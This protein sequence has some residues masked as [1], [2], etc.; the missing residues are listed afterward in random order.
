LHDFCSKTR[1]L[2]GQIDIQT[3]K[4]IF[5]DPVE[6]SSGRYCFSIRSKKNDKEPHYF[7]VNHPEEILAWWKAIT[8]AAIQPSRQLFV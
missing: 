7:H 2:S 3:D 8:K 1:E 5:T 4:Y 6:I